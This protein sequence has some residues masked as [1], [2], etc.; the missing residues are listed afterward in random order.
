M[1]WQ[2]RAAQ[3]KQAERERKRLYYERNREQ[4]LAGKRAW[5]QRHRERNNQYKREHR[6]SHIDRERERERLGAARRLAADPDGVLERQR[7]YYS[8]NREVI[9]RQVRE[10]ARRQK[11]SITNQEWRVIAR[12][13]R[14]RK[15]TK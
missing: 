10:R 3:R 9:A 11:E 5:H 12:R 1:T 2:E 6:L 7:A 4:I 8:A 13:A 15:E 14:A